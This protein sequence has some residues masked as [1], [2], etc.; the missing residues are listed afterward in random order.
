[1]AGEDV[2]VH[3]R[4]VAVRADL[5][6]DDDIEHLF[7]VLRERFGRVDSLVNVAGGLSVIR[8]VSDTTPD[9]WQRE[10][11][12]NAETVLRMSRAALPLLRVSR[13]TIINFAAPAGQRAAANLGA[14]SA[15]KGAVIALT[16]ALALEEKAHGVRVNAIAPGTMDTEQN[17][18]DASSGDAA[19]FV[20]RDDV[21]SVVLFLAGSESRGISGETIRVM[22]PTLS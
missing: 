10:L 18:R 7:A 11:S 17:R 9:E 16:R 20:S 2:A 21:A 6:S 5:T 13:G 22:G 19:E 14:Y 12:R 3:G 1:M 15:A 4:V 8:A